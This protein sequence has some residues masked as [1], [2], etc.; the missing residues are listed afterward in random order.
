MLTNPTYRV[1]HAHKPNV[2]GNTCSQTQVS[3]STQ[4]LGSQTQILGS[5]TQYNGLYKVTCSQTQRIGQYMLTNPSIRQYTDTYMLTNPTYWT[6]ENEA[7]THDHREQSKYTQ[8][9]EN[10]ASTH[11]PQRTKQVHKENKASTL[12]A[13]KAWHNMKSCIFFCRFE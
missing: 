9:K 1:I 10:K 5:Q 8:T 7:S 3:G 11:K 6:P 12:S 2:S 4:I 13:I